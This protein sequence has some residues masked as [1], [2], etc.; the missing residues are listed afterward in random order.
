MKQL[1]KFYYSIILLAIG[2][3]MINSQVR[4]GD[5]CAGM[6]GGLTFF[7]FSF[8]YGIL[9][10]LYLI[11]ESTTP[12]VKFNVYPLLSTLLVIAGVLLALNSE[13]FKGSVKLY[14]EA[15]SPGYSLTLRENGNFTFA[16]HETEWTCYYEGKYQIKNDTLTLSRHDI[17]VLT[18]GGMSDI[19]QID[20]VKNKLYPIDRFN[21]DTTYWFTIEPGL[22][23]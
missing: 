16:Q 3:F 1:K 14:A 6:I 2:G 4:W 13:K 19:Y 7:L 18:D 8:V 12:K 21:R 22:L 11:R 9:F 15:A 5:G 10:L 20:K 17:L 23:Q